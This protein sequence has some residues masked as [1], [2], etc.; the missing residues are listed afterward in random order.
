MFFSET[1]VYVSC[2][3]SGVPGPPLIL[4]RI[5]PADCGSAGLT[6]ATSNVGDSAAPCP[7]AAQEVETISPAH[8]IAARM[9]RVLLRRYRRA[10]GVPPQRH[11]TQGMTAWRAK[12]WAKIDAGA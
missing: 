12:R 2:P 7:K 9:V 4:M 1:F 10:A 11:P 8:R 3:G 5:I 6:E